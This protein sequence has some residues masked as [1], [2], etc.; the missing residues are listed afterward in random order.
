MQATQ[1]IETL[2]HYAQEHGLL[3]TRDVIFARNLLLSTLHMAA[4]G[5]TSAPNPLPPTATPMLEALCVHA[6]EHG[7]I[8][9]LPFV[10]E[11]FSAHLMNLLTPPPSQVEQAFWALQQAHGTQAAADWFYALCR[12][13]DY[14]R[15]D[16]IAK[17]VAFRA[18]SRYGELE[19]TINL[20]KPEKDPREIAKLKNA[21][22]VG[23]PMCML[24]PTN[25]GYEGRAGYPSHET[26]RMIALSMGGEDWFFQYSPYSYYPEHCIVLNAKHIP[27]SI[28]LR[29]FRL[30]MTFVDQFSHYFI[31]SNADLPIVGG[32]ILN[33]D[34]FQGGRHVFPMDK[35][36]AIDAFAHPDFPGVRIETVRWPMTCLRLTS[37]DS[38]ALVT[39]AD[40]LLAAW[41][42]Y[43]DPARDILHE[44]DA[45][46]NT[47]T[48]IL[49]K[50]EDG[51]YCLHLVL[52]NNRV[53]A[54]HPLGIFHPHADL[55]HIKRENIGLIEVMGLFVLPSRLRDELAAL[56]DFLTGV[57]PLAA[58]ADD[59]PLAK[60]YAWMEGIASRQA[61]PLSSEEASSVLRAA[62]TEKCVRVLEDSG[63][64]KLTPDGQAGLAGFLRTV[65]MLPA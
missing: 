30:L 20:S 33:H 1:A 60:H 19:I 15:V 31:G 22:S 29:T 24:C 42:A 9:D 27:M 50:A 18:D 3:S 48:P 34:H 45:P 10:R 5:E 4:P 32:S 62:L 55:H 21:P 51:G 8:E 6:A 49:R 11:Q 40:R 52:R 12:S 44:T 47:I 26:L 57:R 43:D 61:R 65:G 59:D 28:T 54:E 56:E 36:P 46:H 7:I 16:Q 41:R 25:E 38:E 17:N 37:F 64:Y 13:N 58:P 35:A 14:I 63:V 53:T 23:Y 2:L 39:L